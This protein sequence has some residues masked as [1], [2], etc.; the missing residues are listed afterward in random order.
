MVSR[1]LILSLLLAASG[2]H[3]GAA[4]DALRAS[5]QAAAAVADRGGDGSLDIPDLADTRRSLQDDEDDTTTTTTSSTT[6]SANTTT[7]TTAANMT[8]AMTAA[9]TTATTTFANTT[10]SANTTRTTTSAN[11]TTTTT[12]STTTPAAIVISEKCLS[13]LT[14]SANENGA[15]K[16][17]SYFVF[18]D[19][20]SNGY[21]TFNNMTS[22]SDLPMTNKFGFVTLSCQ[23]HAFGGRGNCCQGARAS[24]NVNG[25]EDPE[26]MSLQLAEY[27]GDICSTTSEAIGENTM[28]PTGELPATMRPTSSSAPSPSA[29]P[30]N[31]PTKPPVVGSAVVT[32]PGIGKI[33]DGSDGSDGGLSTAAWT[34]IA[35]AGAAVVTLMIYL[36][37]G[38]KNDDNDDDDSN[39]VATDNDLEQ[40]EA[41]GTRK[42]LVA[43]TNGELALDAPR[44]IESPD[45]TNSMTAS[46]VSSM[47]SMSTNG[48][49]SGNVVS[50]KNAFYANNSLLPGRPDEESVL[51]SNSEGP[52]FFTDEDT[53]ASEGF[54]VPSSGGLGAK[55][56][57]NALNT[58]NNSGESLDQAIESGNWE[59]VAA[60]AARIVKINESTKSVKM[61]T[62]AEV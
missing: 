17:E 3:H 12:T 6:T 33:I 24:L 58:S 7:A 54:E 15:I 36:I 1:Q 21:Y 22:Y 11:T 52:S 44:R 47:H 45:A 62:S 46:D 61:G 59:A 38:R 34:G 9:N 51:S 56:S 48:G 14:A 30:T 16:K 43:I 32:P 55:D 19:G 57:L 41:Q 10:T 42:Q 29:E 40:I 53:V 26:N 31:E 13:L 27:I 28:K 23:C 8:T 18:S 25:I 4:A 60:S 49:G 35:L 50:E 37:T 39:N 5:S 2:S 20:M